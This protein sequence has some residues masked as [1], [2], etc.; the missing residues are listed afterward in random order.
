LLFYALTFLQA[1]AAMDS[2][3]ENGMAESGNILTKLQDLLPYDKLIMKRS[4]LRHRA[5]TAV[6]T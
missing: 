5:G 2:L 3:E 6:L 1:R 4:L